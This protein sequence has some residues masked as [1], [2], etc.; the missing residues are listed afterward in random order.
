M[1]LSYSSE[2]KLKDQL[3]QFLGTENVE[4][5]QGEIIMKN[6]KLMAM[7]MLSVLMF[8]PMMMAQENLNVP[9]VAGQAVESDM[10]HLDVE[11]HSS[12]GSIV[13]EISSYFERYVDFA[14][15]KLWM[16]SSNTNPDF[17]AQIFPAGTVVGIV[18]NLGLYEQSEEVVLPNRT[19]TSHVWNTNLVESDMTVSGLV[20]Q[21]YAVGDEMTWLS[22]DTIQ[23]LSGDPALGSVQVSLNGG[24][25]ENLVTGP[26]TANFPT[27]SQILAYFGGSIVD[28]GSQ[29][30]SNGGP[31]VLYSVKIDGVRIDFIEP[32][33]DTSS[34]EF[35]IE[36]S[37]TT[38]VN[39]YSVDSFES[40]IVAVLPSG[41]YDIY[42]SIV[43]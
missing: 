11:A 37:V 29:V 9:V 42:G 17:V 28:S 3:L 18:S 12:L 1:V 13:A 40:N 20:T 19:V 14:G 16:S 27:D 22:G 15:L 2:E 41:S 26:P 36:G 6:K 32:D 38:L 8:A 21:N 23:I 43:A 35:D 24:A 31:N 7:L 30:E 39:G 10:I 33:A 34:F 25:S 4:N 5:K